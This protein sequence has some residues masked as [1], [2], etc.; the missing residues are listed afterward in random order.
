MNF[1]ILMIN[2]DYDLINQSLIEFLCIEVYFN[3]MIF[4]HIF[5]VFMF[6]N[7]DS[8]YLFQKLAWDINSKNYWTYKVRCTILFTSFFFVLNKWYK[9]MI[10]FNFFFFVFLLYWFFYTFHF[11]SNTAWINCETKKKLFTN[12]YCFVYLFLLYIITNFN[13]SEMIVR[14]LILIF[15]DIYNSIIQRNWIYN[16]KLIFQLIY[17][18]KR[19]F[20]FSYFFFFTAIFFFFFDWLNDN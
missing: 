16:K 10:L 18:K 5:I 19:N 12:L 9:K 17:K 14:N 11:L 20:F 8:F 2:Y 15:L 7:F 4:F 13:G 3:S 6:C 1:Y